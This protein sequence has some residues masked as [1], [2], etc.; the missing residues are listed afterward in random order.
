MRVR[1]G[2]GSP[3]SVRVL[4][5]AIWAYF[6]NPHGALEQLDALARRALPELEAS[7]DDCGLWLVFW[8][9]STVAYNRG[10]IADQIVV[11]GAQPDSRP[12][13]AVAPV[14]RL[15]ARGPGAA[16]YQGPTPV[17]E[18]LAW[19]DEHQSTTSG[20][21]YRLALCRAG[22][23]AMSGAADEAQAIVAAVRDELRDRG[24]SPTLR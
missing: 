20:R 8:G 24:A 23:L 21:S 22:A 11:D 16:R 17:P 5:V 9:L 18:L 12:A 14:P 15:V 10:Q 4:E 7:G 2:T 19:L 1:P 6:T 13:A 3:S